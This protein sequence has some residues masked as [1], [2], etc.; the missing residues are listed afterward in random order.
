MKLKKKLFKYKDSN[1]FMVFQKFTIMYYKSFLYT[2]LLIF[3]I[4]L[5]SF[6]SHSL[7]IYMC[8]T[9]FFYLSFIDPNEKLIYL[10]THETLFLSFV[11]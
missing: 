8:I 5:L 4:C 9:I 11:K 2:L 10:L 1:I 3:E 6:K 7:Y